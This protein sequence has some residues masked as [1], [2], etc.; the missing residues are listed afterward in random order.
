M[1][2]VSLRE[3][4][5]ATLADGFRRATLMIATSAIVAAVGLTT[6]SAASRGPEAVTDIAEQ[7]LDAVVNISTTQ[8]VERRSRERP[9]VEVPEGSP[10]EDL[11]EDFFERD[12]DTPQS[13]NVN[14]LGSGFVIDPAG[15]VITNNHVI[16]DADTILVN[17]TD[18]SELEATV[19]GVDS[20]TDLAVLKV[21]PEAP[22][23]FVEFGASDGLRIG[24][25]VLAIGNPFGLG[26]TVTAGII[27]ATNR[28]INA[29]PYDDFIQT[30]ASINRGNSGGPLFDMDGKVIGINTAIISPFGGSVGIGFAVPADVAVPVIAQL[31]EFGET[32]RGWLG[33]RIQSVSDEI[34]ESLGM[35]RAMGA[36]IAGVTPEGPAE[37]AGLQ[38]GDVVIEF[39]GKRVNEMRELPRI[40]ADTPAET[41]V[42][43]QILR[44]GE[45]MT[46]AV[47]VGLLEEDNGRRADPEADEDTTEG[48]TVLGL[49]LIEIDDDAREEYGLDDDLQG[50]VITAVDP[51]SNGA[52]KGLTVGDV[53][54][55]VSQEPVGTPDEFADRVEELK[56]EDRRSALLLVSGSSGDMRFVALR[57]D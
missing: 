14:S 26:G 21:E 42:D 50:V 30:D 4:A 19:L 46:L 27:S 55:E 52:E 16:A 39:D 13:R 53:V 45:E 18:G 1:K 6:V 44:D 10:F 34:A 8:L 29:G 56:G 51:E 36:L 22:L 5:S 40:V 7:S 9:R 43:V 47:G 2:P 11:F 57:I 49:T 38:A 24:E 3:T 37:A 54:T 12:E 20:K 31:R 32:R 15:I 33:V 28:D 17:F 23:P 25:W 35:E 48:R 41:T